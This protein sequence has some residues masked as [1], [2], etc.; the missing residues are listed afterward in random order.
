MEENFH[1]EIYCQQKNHSNERICGDVFVSERI[2]AEQ[3]IIS[4]LCDGMG[5]GVKANVLATLSARMVLNFTRDNKPFKDLAALISKTLPVCSVRKTSYVTFTA[6]DIDFTGRIKILEYDNPAC[7]LIRE[8]EPKDLE[9]LEYQAIGQQGR[10]M[11]L[12]GANLELQKEDRIVFCSDGITQSGTGGKYSQGWGR[13][14]LMEFVKETL[15]RSPA[16]SAKDLS[17][18]VVARAVANDSYTLDD[19]CSCA[20]IYLRQPRHLLICTGPPFEAESDKAFAEKFNRFEGRKII[21]GSTTAD[22]ISREL[23]LEITDSNEFDDPELPPVSAMEGAELITEGM[24]TLNKVTR[25]L[26]QYD[27]ETLLGKGPA[28]RIVDNLLESDKIHF[29]VGTRINEAHQDPSLPV[30]LEIRRNVIKRLADVLVTRHLKE[31]VV[32]YL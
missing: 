20:V 8:G 12:R 29:L 21:C 18:R 3:R 30:E 15:R 7:F 14:G 32:E 19:D 11:L 4:V 31:V 23:S 25:I 13:E 10:E 6:L 22:I 24:L 5:H 28:D 17:S 1:I 9:W 26:K 16:I 2:S 27:N